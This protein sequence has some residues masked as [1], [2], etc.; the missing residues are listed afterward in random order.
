MCTPVVGPV[1]VRSLSLEM[2]PC[3]QSGVSR[4][5]A[6]LRAPRGAG[7]AASPRAER[8]GLAGGSPPPEGCRPATVSLPPGRLSAQQEL[9][10]GPNASP[11][12]QSASPGQSRDQAPGAAM[13]AQASCV[14]VGGVCC[15]AWATPALSPRPAGCVRG[16]T[17]STGPGTQQ[18]SGKEGEK[19]GKGP[20]PQP[21][22]P[23]G[24]SLGPGGGGEPHPAGPVAVGFLRLSGKESLSR[25][26][27]SVTER[28][29]P[30]A[31]SQ[32][33]L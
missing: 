8:L 25:L 23:A 24:E 27:E 20:S 22:V 5:R 6:G 4:R 28:N 32:G 13:Q 19:A 18:Q 11:T 14:C 12:W 3:G 9:G 29:A 17:P 16:R 2:A 10:P 1:P 26:P 33:P 31:V 15:V 21:A 7:G 30:S